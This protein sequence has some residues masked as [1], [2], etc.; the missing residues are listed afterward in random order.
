MRL[1]WFQ[2]GIGFYVAID[3]IHATNSTHK[4][5][6]MNVNGVEKISAIIA[7]KTKMRKN[8]ISFLLSSEQCASEM[9][10]CANKS[11]NL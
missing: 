3:A 5:Y 8:W 10:V 9:V 6:E 2:F 4:N 7:K 11:G 1:I